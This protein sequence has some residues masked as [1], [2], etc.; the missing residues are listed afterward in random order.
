MKVLCKHCLNSCKKIGIVI[1]N[2]YSPINLE[3]LNL[4]RRKLIKSGGNKK[5]IIEIDKYL[6]YINYGYEK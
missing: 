5:R 2:I 1:C 3:S 6:D 4:E